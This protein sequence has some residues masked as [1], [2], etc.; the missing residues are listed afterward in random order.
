MQI[1]FYG[2][3]GTVTGSKYL[4][5][6]G[7]AATLVDCGLFQGF[8]QLRLRN[9]QPLPL[10]PKRIPGVRR[11]TRTN[12]PAPHGAAQE[13]RQADRRTEPGPMSRPSKRYSC[14]AQPDLRR[15]HCYGEAVQ[16][17]PCSSR[18]RVTKS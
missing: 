5:D 10:D 4:F 2:A 3:T 15:W 1:S 16:S 12:A 7:A 6:D 17:N 18:S 11:G 8:K 14:T 9:W 13:P